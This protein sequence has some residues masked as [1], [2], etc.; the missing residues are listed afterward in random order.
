VPPTGAPAFWLREVSIA[1]HAEIPFPKDLVRA[2]VSRQ[3]KLGSRRDFMK[4]SYVVAGV[5]FGEW[6]LAHFRTTISGGRGP[7]VVL[8]RFRGLF[9]FKP[10]PFLVF[11]FLSTIVGMA[12]TD[13]LLLG[14]ELRPGDRMKAWDR[15]ALHDTPGGA[16]AVTWAEEEASCSEPVPARLGLPTDGKGEAP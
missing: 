7:S 11:W 6:E 1:L 16:R 12:A 2:D 13:R 5:F 14:P 10:Q 3:D 8:T 15:R 9:L 4:D